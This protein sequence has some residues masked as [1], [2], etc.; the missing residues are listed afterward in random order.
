MVAAMSAPLLR[1]TF[2]DL[3]NVVDVLPEVCIGD[4]KALDT[5]ATTAKAK[6]AIPNFIF[7]VCLFASDP[8]GCFVGL[9][10]TT[11]KRAIFD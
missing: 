1:R 8:R 2:W 7:L 4:W 10:A 3:L 5:P 9:L 6:S 11:S